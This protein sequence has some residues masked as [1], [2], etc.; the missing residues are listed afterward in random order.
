MLE[1]RSIAHP[2]QEKTHTSSHWNPSVPELTFRTIVIIIILH[3]F[4]PI[5]LRTVHCRV[6]VLYN[7]FRSQCRRKIYY[8]CGDFVVTIS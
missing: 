7:I 6:T 2:S 4:A 1:Y 5:K 8:T 3:R